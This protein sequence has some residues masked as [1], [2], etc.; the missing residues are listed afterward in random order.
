MLDK[1]HAVL[2]PQVQIKSECQCCTDLLLETRFINHQRCSF[3]PQV[4]DI[5]ASMQTWCTP[6]VPI[7]GSLCYQLGYF[8]N[9]LLFLHALFQGMLTYPMHSTG[10]LEPQ[11]VSCHLLVDYILEIVFTTAAPD[12]DSMS[13]R[14]SIINKY[15]TYV[16]LN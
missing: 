15:R 8:A 2:Q 4:A 10:L 1:I 12:F 6:S 16:C 13:G 14:V 3:S 5:P 7:V 9:M 11:I